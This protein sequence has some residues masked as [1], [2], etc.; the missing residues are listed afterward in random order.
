M[1]ESPTVVLNYV[2]L[3]PSK[4]NCMRNGRM[5][6]LASQITTLYIQK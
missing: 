6:V 1:K 4:G 5:N 3:S 2:T